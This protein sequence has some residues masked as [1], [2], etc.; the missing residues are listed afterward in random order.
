MDIG[1]LT[2]TFNGERVLPELID[3]LSRQRTD[4]SWEHVIVDNGS[5]DGTIALLEEYRDR[6]G[7]P[8]KILD[9]S[10]RAGNIPYVR[11][12]AAK[13]ASAELLVYC[14]QDDVV[15]DGWIE[16]AYQGLSCN[17]AIMGRIIQ[18]NGKGAGRLMNPSVFSESPVVESCNLGVRRSVLRAVGGFDEDLAGYGMD[19]SELA[20]RLRKSG[21]DIVGAPQMVIRARRS[22]GIRTR[23][24]KVFSSARTEVLVWGKHP[25]VFPGYATWRY[26][27]RETLMIPGVVIRH[28]RYRNL[29]AVDRCARVVVTNVAHYSA[30]IRPRKT[31][32]A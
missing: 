2:V 29:A 21:I 4:L 31:G 9:G 5:S 13:N 17:G 10:D 12:V 7:H 14:D 1:V 6:S 27:C 3:S 15:E 30:L 16:G 22:T 20:I 26:V 32:A 11:N 18:L 25:D 8:V 24:A 19:D 28:A 23:V